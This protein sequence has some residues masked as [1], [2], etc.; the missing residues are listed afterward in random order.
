[1]KRTRSCAQWEGPAAA[2]LLLKAA[3]R[4]P[5]SLAAAEDDAPAETGERG[6]PSMCRR[7]AWPAPVQHAVGTVCLRASWTERWTEGTVVTA[8]TAANGGKKRRRGRPARPAV[9]TSDAS[10]SN[11]P[12]FFFLAPPRGLPSH[13]PGAYP[14]PHPPNPV[15]MSADGLSMDNFAFGEISTRSLWVVRTTL[16]PSLGRRTTASRFPGNAPRWPT[17]GTPAPPPPPHPPS[18][19]PVHPCLLNHPPIPRRRSA[20]R[21]SPP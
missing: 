18:P 9:A 14:P 3:L 4:P 7:I 21:C 12:R 16:G 15:R 13:R 8:G 10:G 11:Q 20:S 6:S 5:P 2:P 19:H 1:M 17:F